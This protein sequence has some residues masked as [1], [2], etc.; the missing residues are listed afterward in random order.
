MADLTSWAHFHF[1]GE[2]ADFLPADKDASAV[3]YLLRGPVAV[4]HLIEALG[5]PHTEVEAI[6]TG[7]RP[8]DF[9]YRVQA[10]DQID[11]YPAHFPTGRTF[12]QPLR[13]Q[14]PIPASFVADGH[15]G[16]LT[17]YLRLLGF[18]TLYHNNYGDD[19]LALLAHHEQRILLTRDRRLLMRK[20]VVYGQCLRSRDPWQQLQ[21]VIQ[22]FLLADQIRPWQRCLRCNGL[23]RPVSKQEIL[24]RLEPKTKKYYHEF[25]ICQ[26][27]EQIYWKGSH[28][29]PLQ[30]LVEA[31]GRQI[32]SS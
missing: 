27:C 9:F 10:G 4:K 30:E 6:F 11:V 12:H 7:G 31:I 20:M 19:E 1:W 28:Y 14:R 2:L 8:V 23:L 26:E 5:I 22:R 24:D 17:T 16:R 18:D 29:Q 21:A 32:R 3:P 13:P 15:L 25:H